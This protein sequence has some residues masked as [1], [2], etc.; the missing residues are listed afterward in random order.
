M[1]HNL[2]LNKI[3]GTVHIYPTLAELNKYA[4]GE[5]KRAHVPALA[6]K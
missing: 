6:M 5:W 3:L 2:S 4:T 1:K